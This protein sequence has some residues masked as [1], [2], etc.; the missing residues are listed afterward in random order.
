MN[1]SVGGNK[2]CSECKRIV[3]GGTADA[4]QGRA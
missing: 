2:A 3:I 1:R 4:A